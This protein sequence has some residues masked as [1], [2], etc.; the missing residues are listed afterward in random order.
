MTTQRRTDRRTGPNG[1]LLVV[2]AFVCRGA[3]PTISE[4]MIAGYALSGYPEED[5]IRHLEG[6]SHEMLLCSIDPDTKIDWT[7]D[8]FEQKSLSPLQPPNISYQ[9][10]AGHDDAFLR[11]IEVA[12]LAVETGALSPDPTDKT[13]WDAYFPHNYPMHAPQASLPA[14]DTQ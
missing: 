7:R 5:I 1:Q 6:A 11:M 12:V 14:T 13:T 4:Y 2:S 10:V 8:L 3:H 9:I